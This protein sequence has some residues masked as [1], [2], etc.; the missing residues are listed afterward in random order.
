MKF[1]NKKYNAR[2]PRIANILDVYKMNGSFEIAKIAGIESTANNTS[3]NS[4]TATTTSK[5]VAIFTLF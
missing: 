1:D 4:I 3:V 2:K 5:G